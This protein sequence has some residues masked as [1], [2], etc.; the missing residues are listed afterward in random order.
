[1]KRTKYV[2][3]LLIKLV[4]MNIQ[5]LK[6][7]LLKQILQSESKE[8]LDKIYATLRGEEKDFWLEMT[9]D[10]KIEIEIGK[11]QVENGETEEWNSV[12]K[13]LSKKG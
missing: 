10:Q 2:S 8:L 11:R 5:A 4:E 9:E 13:R 12:L 6:I 7:E 3:L 1:M